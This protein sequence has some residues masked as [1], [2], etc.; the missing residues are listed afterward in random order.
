MAKRLVW[1]FTA[2]RSEYGLMEP[3][4]NE[5]NKSHTLIA[6]KQFIEPSF[7]IGEIA[8]YVEDEL[9]LGKPDIAIVPCDR[10]EMVPVAMACFFNNVPTIHYYAGTYSFSGTHD[11]VSRHV[12][13]MFSHIM[14]CESEAARQILIKGGEEEWRVVVSGGS[15]FD[16][17]KI[18]MDLCP[19]EPYNL[20]LLLPEHYGDNNKM[21]SKAVKELDT[22][23]LVVVIA[24]N[25]DKESE[26]LWKKM[27][28]YLMGH[29]TTVFESLP[30]PQFLGLMKKCD[31]FVSNSSSTL[32]EAPYLG[33]KVFNPSIRNSIRTLPNIN[34]LMGGSKFL[35]SLCEVI[36]IN[37]PKLLMKKVREYP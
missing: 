36:D 9:K 34:N 2:S 5:M 19:K 21:I 35:S 6:K 23:K 17:I 3:V 11:D 31:K 14:C 16:D 25:E 30:R 20:F 18:D 4:I 15:H 13:S 8:E 26:K 28:W 29:R 1:I 33:A 32:F 24:P 27:K 37:D 7:T 12:I 22:N 10:R